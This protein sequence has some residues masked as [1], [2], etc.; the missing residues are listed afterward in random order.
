MKLKFLGTRGEI[1]L[2]TRLHAMH[3]SAVVSYRGGQVTVDCGA[4][5]L[6][7]VFAMRP[8]AIVL[9]HGHPDHAWGLKNGAPCKVFATEETW[10]NLAGAPIADRAVVEPRKPFELN[11]ITFE[12]FPV[13]HSIRC[14]AVGYRIT[15]GRSA[16]FYVPDLV[17]IDDTHEALRDIRMYI[18]DGASLTRPM[19]RR[20]GDQ[21]FGHAAIRTQLTWCRSEEVPAAVF[22]HCGSEIV[23]GDPAKMES[24]VRDLGSARGVN[25]RLAF[26][27]LEIILP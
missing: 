27:G 25:A 18:G 23:G 15:A 13:R 5:W 2:R 17:H 16:V 10:T 4:D 3:S 26:D 11:G 14:P 1:D 20:Q 19:V 22:T 6:D 21:L 12:A 8:R 24:A 7:R 9:T